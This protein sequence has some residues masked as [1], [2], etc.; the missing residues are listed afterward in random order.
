MNQPTKTDFLAWNQPICFRPF[1]SDSVKRSRGLRP[2]AAKPRGKALGFSLKI[3]CAPFS[4]SFGGREFCGFPFKN[5][6]HGYTFQKRHT[7]YHLINHCRGTAGQAKNSDNCLGPSQLNGDLRSGNRSVCSVRFGMSP[8]TCT[9][10]T[11][12]EYAY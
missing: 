1:Q 6:K 5:T 7:Q 3:G 10:S 11:A 2:C 8:K 9:G 4:F 12:E